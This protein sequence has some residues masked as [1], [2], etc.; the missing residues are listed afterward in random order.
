MLAFGCGQDPLRYYR[1]MTRS[2]ATRKVTVVLPRGLLHRAMRATGK[3][4]SATVRIGLELLV[5]R[6]ACDRLLK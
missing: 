1:A 5:A 4:I 2:Q 6:D 3:G